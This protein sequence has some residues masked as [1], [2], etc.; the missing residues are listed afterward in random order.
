MFLKVVH[1][2]SVYGKLN[3]K[4]GSIA[5]RLPD[6][7]T[8]GLHDERGQEAT[9]VHDQRDRCNEILQKRED[10]QPEQKPFVRS[11]ERSRHTAVYI[12]WSYM[13]IRGNSESSE[14]YVIIAFKLLKICITC[15]ILN[16]P[17]VLNS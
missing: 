10:A 12:Y 9:E 7:F 2:D 8:E 16:Q 17:K 6:A 5:Y 4:L 11:G 15:I 14:I 1:H 3:P 13:N